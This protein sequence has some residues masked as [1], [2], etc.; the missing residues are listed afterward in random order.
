VG[1]PP[2]D[3]QDEHNGP[4][5]SKNGDNGGGLPPIPV[6]PAGS[7]VP[8]QPP[9]QPQQPPLQPP[10]QQQCFAYPPLPPS[11]PTSSRR[12]SS[13]LSYKDPV[14]PTLDDEPYELHVDTYVQPPPKRLWQPWDDW[15]PY[16]RWWYGHATPEDDHLR[17]TDPDMFSP[18]ELIGD[19]FL[20]TEEHA[21]Q[22]KCMGIPPIPA[23]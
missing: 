9:V 1:L 19:Q 22:R 11:S 16:A 21:L 18:D 23:S 10:Q 5:D 2:D 7:Q 4:P 14:P 17:L 8:W 13:G 6:E 20:N 3:L 15:S 12:S